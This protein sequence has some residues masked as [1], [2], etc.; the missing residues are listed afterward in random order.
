VLTIGVGVGV[1]F[2][3]NNTGGGAPYLGVVI[4][5]QPVSISVDEPDAAVFM[6]A[7]TSS[8]PSPITF[9]WQFFS[10]TW[11]DFLEGGD[12]S[13]STTDTLT[14]SPTEFI[15]DG[16]QIRCNVSN[17]VNTVASN[18]VTL[19][20]V[21]L[22]YQGVTITIQPLNTNVQEPNVAQFFVEATSGDL[23]PLGY[24]WQIFSGTWTT[25][26]DDAVYSGTT[27]D[28]LSIITDLP[29][30]G[31]QYRSVVNNDFNSEN[32]DSATLTVSAQPYQGVTITVQPSNDSV[33]EPDPASF[34]VA[35]TS[36]DGSPLGYKWQ[37]FDVTWNNLIDGGAISGA[38]T[39]TLTIDPTVYATDDGNNYRCVVNNDFNFENSDTAVLSI[40]ELPYQ[41]ITITVQPVS[42]AVN[43]PDPAVF[44]ITV[45][46][47]DLSVPTYQWQ[48]FTG[49]WNDLANGGSISGV[50]TDTL[51]IDPTEVADTGR[52]FR[53]VATNDFNFENSDSATL[54]VILGSNWILRAG[55]W[56]DTGDWEDDAV[57][58]DLP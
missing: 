53:C 36:G 4:T 5:Q 2:R 47:G 13:G 27:T 10:G 50:T 31:N 3:T 15:D 35:A 58:K 57:W 44:T 37:E 54:T 38:T 56:D 25:L 12:I 11:Q 9:Q 6:V 52:S 55:F 42:I 48:E 1:P 17:D 49:T 28:T 16:T 23:S 26:S 30:S 43:E 40:V 18:A 24:K 19:T 14:I 34:S 39:S 22:P 7:A 29:L 8:D 33:L 45:T 46:S 41:G 32:S 20:V 21:P 51:T